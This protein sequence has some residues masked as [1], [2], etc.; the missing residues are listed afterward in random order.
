MTRTLDT[1]SAPI[2]QTGPR[3]P[4]PRFRSPRAV[5]FAVGVPFIAFAGWLLWTFP[6]GRPWLLC[7]A[8]VLGVVQWLNG[9]T[10]LVALPVLIGTIDLGAW[11]G[12]FLF[13][14][15]D[16]LLAMLVGVALVSGQYEGSGRQLVRRDFA[17]LWLVIVAVAVG[18][19]R[20]L[21]PPLELDANAWNGYLTG[22]NA[23]RIAKGPFWALV[24]WPLLGRQLDEDRR[25]TETAL[26][27][28]M[29]AALVGLGFLVLWERGFAWTCSEP[30][31][32]WGL[33]A[34]W[35]DLSG[36]YRITGP[37]SQMHLGGEAVDGFL[38]LCWP[39]ACLLLFQARRPL[40]FL[41]ALLAV[42]LAA[43]GVLVTFTRTT[44]AATA[45]ALLAFGM[46][47][48]SGTSTGH[49]LRLA[50]AALYAVIAAGVF[51]HGFS[52]GGTLTAGGYLI[53]V[54]GAIC[55]TMFVQ[56]PMAMAPLAV[57]LLILLAAGLSLAVHGMTASKWNV[58]DARTAI[59]TTAASALVLGGGGLAT[60]VALRPFAWTRTG[61][62]ILASLTVLL[63]I[64]TLS[65]SGAQME[66]RF[67]LVSRDLDVRQRH[68]REVL[69]LMPDDLQ[70]TAFGMGL[71]R[72]PRASLFAANDPI[73]T[74]H[75]GREDS[76][77]YLRLLGTASLC[78]GQ[79]ALQLEPGAYR[80]EIGLRN[81]STQTANLAVKLQPRRL[82]ESESWQP[83]T[84]QI[85]F[86]VEPGGSTWKH[87]EGELRLN[88]S[89]SPPWYDPRFA[90][91][92]LSNQGDPQSAVDVAYVRLID[93]SGRDRLDNG[94]FAAGGDRWFAYN[95]F[96][97]LE[98]H[99]KNFYIAL[100]FDMGA[101]GLAAFS[102]ACLVALV[103]SWRKAQHSSPFGAATFAAIVGF[104]VLGTTGTLL[105]V[106]QLMTLMLVVVI[107]ALW[108]P[109]AERGLRSCE[110]L[111]RSMLISATCARRGVT[112]NGRSPKY[113]GLVAI[114]QYP[115]LAVPPDGTGQRHTLDIASDGGQSRRDRASGQPAGLP[116]R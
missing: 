97:H 62:A 58:V 51:I 84:Q 86:V 107:A 111:K 63:P 116:V 10:W 110:P 108:R 52:L 81:P 35:L 96:Q 42:G 65:F 14:E 83:E 2:D 88:V 94:N 20:G 114:Q 68:W 48:L 37:F 8:V 24:L 46:A 29:A 106:P 101:L 23:V 99:A 19:I 26:A 105:D 113:D 15:Q 89:S 103:R 73:G 1:V 55:A 36:S 49:R 102:L 76:Q 115:V 44:Y 6:I 43:Y 80:V 13:S 82:L 38:V 61:A 54:L 104:L 93:P 71:G 90:V 40:L 78:Y 66:Q 59:A 70:T 85:N 9:R 92:A 16:A 33:F 69:A 74:W 95:D 91:F 3:S 12:R 45:V 50:A 75:F 56:R 112:T 98:W 7:L 17:P 27:I 4:A 67:A 47:A 34:T 60:G 21:Q 79:R 77:R 5:Q 39:F 30:R 25:A 41:L 22:W 64:V 53:I 11:S 72:F 87:L 109:A 31:I 57:G 32:V 28:G 18:V 100:L